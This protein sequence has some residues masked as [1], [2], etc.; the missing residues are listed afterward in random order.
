MVGLRK[1]VWRVPAK[2]SLHVTLRFAPPAEDVDDAGAPV[3]ETDEKHRQRFDG[4]L[5]LLYENG[6]A[7]HFALDC[8]PAHARVDAARSSKACGMERTRREPTRGD[9][10]STR[11]RRGGR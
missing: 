2:Q 8:S 4:A 3:R 7:Q 9:A 10:G 1:V 11:R 6:D 5:V